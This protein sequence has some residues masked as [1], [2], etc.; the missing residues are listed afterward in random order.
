MIKNTIDKYITEGKVIRFAGDMSYFVNKQ[1]TGNYSV[2]D[3]TSVKITKAAGMMIFE[4][5]SSAHFITI[6]LLD[7]VDKY[8]L[9][10]QQ[11][12]MRTKGDMKFMVE[13]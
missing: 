6:Q 2:G 12:G 13:L 10:Y 9:N 3:G 5:P 8:K 11:I 7:A 4:Y 1:K